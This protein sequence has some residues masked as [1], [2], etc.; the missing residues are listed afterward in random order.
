MSTSRKCPFPP[1]CSFSG[2]ANP[3]ARTGGTNYDQFPRSGQAQLVSKIKDLTLP[4][5]ENSTELE[6]FLQMLLLS[7]F[8]KQDSTVQLLSCFSTFSLVV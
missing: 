1:A 3:P 4:Q 7:G 8:I 5:V 2:H 6:K